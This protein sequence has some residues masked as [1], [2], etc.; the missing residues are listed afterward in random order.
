MVRQFQIGRSM[1]F[2][3]LALMVLLSTYANAQD[4]RVS[5]RVDSNKITIGDWLKLHLEVEYPN[6]VSVHFPFLADSLNG[7][8]IVRRDSLL[9]K[10]NNGGITES[11][12]YTLTAFDS[13]TFVVPPLTFR[14]SAEGDT[15]TRLAETNPIPIFV[16]G[17]EVD[18]SKDIKD[19]KPPL[20]LSI[21]FADVWPYLLAVV[22]IA[23]IVWLVLYIRRKRQRGESLIPEAPPRP[24]DEVA[25]EALRSLDSEQLWQRGS[26][27]E[28]HSQLTDVIRTYIEQRFSIMAMEMV[29]DEILESSLRQTLETRLQ[30]A[31]REMLVLADL[32]KFAKVSPTPQENEKGMALAVEFVQAT[33]RPV[34]QPQ[35]E[36]A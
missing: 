35:E 13:G 25:L 26:V 14:Y 7:L 12:S 34:A 36:P 23:A 17:I 33:S 28:Y 19:I 18:T 24:A 22:G 21:T 20:S 27:K 8:D 15:T 6:N 4:V 3:I 5:A 2:P 11:M 29:T 9:T 32:V 10:P 16:R 31:L 30:Q 1:V